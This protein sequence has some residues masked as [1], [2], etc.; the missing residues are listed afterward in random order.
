MKKA[1]PDKEARIQALERLSVATREK[2]EPQTYAL[3]LEDTVLIPTRY[4]VEAC[5]RLEKSSAWFPKLKELI[6]ECSTVARWHQDQ[7]ALKRL[8]PAD[9]CDQAR[10]QMW[11]EK[12]KAAS[13]GKRM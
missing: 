3:Y 6:D 9:E 5:G 4:F 7:Q 13:H 8:P 10:A 11:L 2:V 1:L 12:I